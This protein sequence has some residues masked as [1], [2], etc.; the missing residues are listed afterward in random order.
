MIQQVICYFMRTSN[1]DVNT[2][3]QKQSSMTTFKSGLQTK[4]KAF[5]AGLWE[6]TKSTVH[7]QLFYVEKLCEKLSI[8][9]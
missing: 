5:A 7:G 3:N 9:L 8:Q 2:I 1:D 4:I 6:V